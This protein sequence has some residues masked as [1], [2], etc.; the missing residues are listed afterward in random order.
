MYEVIVRNTV[1]KAFFKLKK[2]NKKQLLIIN[3]KV[4][5]LKINPHHYK[6]LKK[7]LQHL[8]RVHIDKSFI[9]LFSVDEDNKTIYVE[10]Y[11]HHDE[12]YQ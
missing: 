10:D 1:E 3:K 4:D 6:N 8:K 7:P 2:K 11:C 5:E 12:A 9:L